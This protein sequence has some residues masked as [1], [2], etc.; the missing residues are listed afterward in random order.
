MRMRRWN[1]GDEGGCGFAE[2]DDDDKNPLSNAFKV[3]AADT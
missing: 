3:A 1:D 2:D